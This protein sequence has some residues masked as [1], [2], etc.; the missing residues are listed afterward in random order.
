MSDYP[1]IPRDEP[2]GDI[3][4]VR[5]YDA[6]SFFLCSYN[7][8]DDELGKKLPGVEYRIKTPSGWYDS[9]TNDVI[10]A[11]ESLGDKTFFGEEA[12]HWLYLAV[13]P[14]ETITSVNG[15]NSGVDGWLAIRNLQGLMGRYAANI[16]TN[17]RPAQLYEDEELDYEGFDKTYR[18][19]YEWADAIW[20]EHGDTYFREFLFAHLDEA[21][22]LLDN[23]GFE[24]EDIGE[25]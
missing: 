1:P 21:V 5:L 3:A 15:K 11:P 25:E 2:L 14:D 20:K 24:W 13:N 7:I 6:L 10:V 12:G 23:L 18:W 9:S 17:G 4:R 16:F 8:P 22:A 19:G